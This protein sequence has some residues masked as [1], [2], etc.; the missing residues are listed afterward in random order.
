MTFIA[1][2]AFGIVIALAGMYLLSVW[3]EWD[4]DD[5]DDIR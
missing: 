3:L 4:I 5:K 2:M 1:G